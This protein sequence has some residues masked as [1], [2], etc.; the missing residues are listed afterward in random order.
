MRNSGE[1]RPLWAII[2]MAATVPAC[3]ASVNATAKVN[4]SEAQV[5]EDRK[6]E[7]AEPASAPQDAPPA[8]VPQAAPRVASAVAAAPAPA[9]A[10]Q[11]LGVVHDLSLSSSAPRSPV[12]RCLALAYGPPSD[13]K[14][15][16]QA[17]P[18][19]DDHDTIAIAI[20]ADGVACPSGPPPVRASISAVGREGTDIVLIVENVSEGRPIMRG[21]LA[22]SPGP[23]GGIVVRT[24]RD[25]P[26]P[27]AS[28]AGPCRVALQ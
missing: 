28:G 17:G 23:G 3:R 4:G 21:A 13:S 10:V 20:A 16:W 8:A 27:A 2:L 22:A 18:P 11:F 1:T 5:D 15:T 14:F 19:G 12:C 9:S 24:R 7:V 6:W 25:M 26:Y